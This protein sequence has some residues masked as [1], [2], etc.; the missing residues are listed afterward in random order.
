MEISDSTVDS[1]DWTP[2]RPGRWRERLIV[3]PDGRRYRLAVASPDAP[4]PE[5]GY[6]S[7]LVLDGAQHFAAAA[8]AAQA[9]ARRPE[10]T[11]VPPM[12]VFGLF[13]DAAGDGFDPD[14]RFRDF[15][16]G[17]GPTGEAEGRPCGG[18]EALRRTLETRVLP[19]M[20]GFAM[21]DDA[22]RAL[23]GHS[24]GG[25]FVL[26]TMRRRP[27]LFARWIAISPSLWWTP[28][29]TGE[30]AG[31]DVMVGCGEGETRRGLRGRIE[32]WAG[33]GQGR[34]AVAP[35]A[36]HGSAPFVLLPEALRHAGGG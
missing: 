5:A 15:T 22:R 34:L 1:L 16:D 4:P 14:A 11:G 10:K 6:P 24:L 21:L 3:E 12:V 2:F 28:A 35:G 20:A 9:L 18:A 36:D 17:P 7:L 33:E 13:H 32:V 27:G 8:G 19:L 26:E 31:A 29:L 23:F 25:L 30:G